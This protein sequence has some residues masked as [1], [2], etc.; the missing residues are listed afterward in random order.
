MQVRSKFPLL[1]QMREIIPKSRLN[2]I[3]IFLAPLFS[4]LH[5]LHVYRYYAAIIMFL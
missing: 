4:V 2:S 1:I 3:Y 5:I